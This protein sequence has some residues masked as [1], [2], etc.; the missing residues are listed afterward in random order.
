[1]QGRLYEPDAYRSGPVEGCFWHD[2]HA[3]DWSGFD[4]PLHGSATAEVAIIGGGFTGLSAALHLAQEHGIQAT[5]LEAEVPGWGASGRN[6]GFACLGGAKASDATI[7]R[8]HGLDD[9]KLFHAAQRASVDLVGGLLDAHGIDA[10]RHSDG[11]VTLAHRPSEMAALEAE[12]AHLRAVAG[13]EGRIIAREE[14]AGE[15]LSGPCF[16]GGLHLPV[17]FALNPFSYVRGLARAVRTAGQTIHVDSPA[18]KIS[19]TNGGWRITTPRGDLTA[20][21]LVIATNGY[22]SD[23]LPRWMQGRILPAMSNIIVTRPLTPDEQ[24]AQGW[25]SDRMSF[26]SRTLLHYFRK[27][28]DGRFLFG[29]RGGTRYTPEDTARMRRLIRA[30]FEAMFP[31]W[32]GVETPYFWSGLIGMTARLAPFVAPIPGMQNAFAGLAY[33]G[34]GVAMGSYSGRI[35]AALAAGKKPDMP[36]PEVMQ[37]V[38]PRI[39]LPRRPLLRLAYR[40]YGW[41][42]GPAPGALPRT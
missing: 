12:A 41:R 25:T 26:D 30:D 33:H 17:G 1:M 18:G 15:G 16:H 28:P 13:I 32:A 23:A 31:A 10:D 11:E 42:D 24:A 34:N 7:R 19:E 14:L 2:G 37:A 36:W 20:R 21:T 22:S 9:L 4:G 40:W 29:M 35:L 8:R 27:M 3:A 6:G 5:V 38:P 39:L